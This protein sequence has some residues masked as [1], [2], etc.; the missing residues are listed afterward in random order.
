VEPIQIAGGLV[1]IASVVLS[2]AHAGSAPRLAQ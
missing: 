2:R 1:V